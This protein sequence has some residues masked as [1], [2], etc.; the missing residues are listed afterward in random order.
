MPVA[1]FEVRGQGPRLRPNHRACGLQPAMGIGGKS[2][3]SSQQA[4]G[5]ACT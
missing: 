4:P 1:G 3:R 5:T 2:T